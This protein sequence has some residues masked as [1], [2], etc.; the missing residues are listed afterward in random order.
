[1]PFRLQILDAGRAGAGNCS[2][3]ASRAGLDLDGRSARAF[4]ASTLSKEMS[5]PTSLDSA[6]RPIAR[7]RSGPSGS[8]LGDPLPVDVGDVLGATFTRNAL[9]ADAVGRPVSVEFT[10]ALSQNRPIATLV[11]PED[12][13]V[14]LG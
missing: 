13:V 11:V 14:A 7:K 8:R 3:L 5:V 1:M 12:P 10:I 4:Q 2:E 9:A 6:V